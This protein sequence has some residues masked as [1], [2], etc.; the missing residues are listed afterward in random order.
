M[1]VETT[2]TERFAEMCGC[3]VEDLLERESDHEDHYEQF[4]NSPSPAQKKVAAEFWRRLWSGVGG[5]PLKD[6]V[7]MQ[8]AGACCDIP[9]DQCFDS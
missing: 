5:L 7:S 3:D 2:T 9:T 6:G 8:V 1:L 4:G